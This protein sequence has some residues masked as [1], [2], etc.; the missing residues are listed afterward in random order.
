MLGD[1]LLRGHSLRV[2]G[3]KLRHQSFLYS[4]YSW[5]SG[6]RRRA[7]G[8]SRLGRSSWEGECPLFPPF[9]LVLPWAGPHLTS[10]GPGFWLVWRMAAAIEMSHRRR[11]WHLQ[12]NRWNGGQPVMGGGWPRSNQ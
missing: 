12:S 1:N 3:G 6:C 10:Q 7:A 9:R 2:G 8:S 4:I 5:A 11:G